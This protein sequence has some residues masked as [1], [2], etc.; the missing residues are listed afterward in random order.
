MRF[1]CS[2]PRP[3]PRKWPIARTLARHGSCIPTYPMSPS[4]N[5][6]DG[7]QRTDTPT[8]GILV[9]SVLPGMPAHQA[10]IRRGDRI[11]AVNDRALADVDAV[12]A[13]GHLPFR[14]LVQ[15]GHQVLEFLVG[16]RTRRADL[17]AM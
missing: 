5:R 12:Q 6:L 16:G 10:G 13:L 2:C 8:R 7:A 1:G 14:V 4:E 9:L 3:L 15:R 11:I 17:T